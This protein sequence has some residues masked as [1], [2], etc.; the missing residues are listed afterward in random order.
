MNA[1][2]FHTFAP[3]ALSGAE[4]NGQ[5]FRSGSGEGCCE[6]FFEAGATSTEF[7]RLQGHV[8]A[9]GQPVDT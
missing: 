2:M 5:I 3:A 8:V 9:Y 4:V 7:G 1:L 6:N